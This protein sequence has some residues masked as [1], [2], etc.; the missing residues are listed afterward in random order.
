MGNRSRVRNGNCGANPA[1]RIGN[2]CHQTRSARK[3]SPNKGSRWF[4]NRYLVT[5]KNAKVTPITKSRLKK[6]EKISP[7]RSRRRLLL[8]KLLRRIRQ[9]SQATVRTCS[10]S[11]GPATTSATR[12]PQAAHGLRLGQRRKGRYLPASK[13]VP[14]RW[15]RRHAAAPSNLALPIAP[16]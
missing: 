3:T 4:S 16:F 1:S 13:L 2:E 5:K 8:R 14:R 15:E 7:I 9:R 12:A 11:P 10:A 6:P